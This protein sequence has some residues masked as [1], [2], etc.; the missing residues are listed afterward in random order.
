MKKFLSVLIVIVTLI[1][2][3]TSSKK[4]LQIGNYDEVIGKSVKKLIKKPTSNK[5]AILL[6]KAYSLANERDIEAIKFLKLDGQ[7]DNWD[8]I[9]RHYEILKNRQKHLRPVLPFKLNG[10][11]IN[12]KQIDYDAEIVEAKRKAAAYFYA[13]G[14]R[15]LESNEKSLIRQAYSEFVRAKSYAGSSYQDIDQLIKEAQ[16]KAISRV[17]VEIQ[18][19]SLFNFPP[20]FIEE[21]I[22]GNASRLNTDWV[23]YFFHN[24][25][26]HIQF[27]YLAIVKI[28]NIQVSPDD[29]KNIDHVF[30]KNVADGAEYVL[31]EKGN[32]KKDTAGND[33]KRIKYKAI[34]CAL[35]ETIQHKEARLT[36]DVEFVELEPLERLIGKKPFGAESVFHHV[37]ARAIGDLEALDDAAKQKVKSAPR[38]FP[39]D[40]E[41]IFNNAVRVQEAINRILRENQAYFK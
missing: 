27:D 33:M 29:V 23:H 4:N 21:I 37:S 15:L 6:D 9:L 5:D 36:G 11:L 28:R 31:D 30:K 34:Q 12:Y 10:E 20:Q 14:K 25:G 8:K 1:T 26:E 3:C 38:A 16:F 41:L 24:P 17:F 19:T 40:Q 13:N 32:V 7:P 18:N 2:A 39:S 22:S 35:V